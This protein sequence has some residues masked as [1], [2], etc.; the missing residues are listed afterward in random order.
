VKG[1]RP[2]RILG[3]S[4]LELMI[5]VVVIGILAAIA[6]PSYQDQMRKGSRAAAQTLIMQVANRESQYLLDARNFAVGPAALTALNV[7]VPADVSIYYDVT[8]TDSVGG[9]TPSTP[10]TYTITATPR[11]GTRQVPDGALT[12]T[13]E[14]AKTRAGNP[15]W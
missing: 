10:P 11:A 6:W 7:S 15:G 14:G 1:S 12:L 9:A 5:T 8:I 2:R 4:L 13:H 3:F